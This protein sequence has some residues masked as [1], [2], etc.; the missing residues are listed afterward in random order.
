MA[1]ARP[2]AAPPAH[3]RRR[4]APA[5]AREP[6]AAAAPGLRGSALD[7]RR[8]P[9]VARQPGREPA[10]RAAP[11]PGQLPPRVP[12]RLGRARPT[13]RQ[14][15]LD[16]LPA[17]SAEELLE[18]LLGADP[19]LA[20]AQAAAD[21]ADRGQP[22]LPRGE[23]ADAGRDRSA[24]GRARRLSPGDDR[25]TAFRCRPRCRRSW[26]RASTGCRP[27]TSGC[28]RRP[29]SSARTCPY[30]LLQA[31]AELPEEMLRRG[32]RPSA[33]GEFLYETQ[34]LPGSRVHLQARA[35]PRSRLREPPPGAAARPA[36]ADRRQ[37]SKLCTRTVWPSR[38]SGWPT[39]QSA[40]KSGRRPW[41]IS[42]RRAPRRL[43]V[44]RTARPSRT[45][46]RR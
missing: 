2:A 10:D 44:P 45:L 28:C 20:T 15:R 39:T 31:I 23:R 8:D 9:G 18:A 33:G 17:E 43:D 4:Q 16:P 32:P 35:H 29:R 24:L 36:R 27:R 41:C 26:P 25:S 46:S 13:T 42:G 14:L 7:R 3:A 5:A 34:S 11:A 12:A 6:G 1:G 22:V 21:R 30:A 19:R 38:S 37:P 40:A